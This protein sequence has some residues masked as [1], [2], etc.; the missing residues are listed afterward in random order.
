MSGA[1]AEREEHGSAG[2]NCSQNLTVRWAND[3]AE[4]VLAAGGCKLGKSWECLQG[5]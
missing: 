5:R 3:A 4:G 1:A 2:Y